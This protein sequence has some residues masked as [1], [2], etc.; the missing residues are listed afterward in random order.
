[1]SKNDTKDLFPATTTI[2]MIGN[3]EK[4][5]IEPND[6]HLEN[7]EANEKN[8][9]LVDRDGA[10]RAELQEHGMTFKE[11]VR[12]YPRAIFWSFAISLCIIMEGY[13]TA[14]PVRL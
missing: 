1:M 11:G 12:L 5:A 2:S 7:V 8:F 14:L 10:I 9:D 6:Q 13:D 4:D 3:D